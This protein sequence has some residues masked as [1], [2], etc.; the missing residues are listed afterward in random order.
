MPAAGSPSVDPATAG[1]L[2]EEQAR[3][4]AVMSAD[5]IMLETIAQQQRMP[6]SAA[7]AALQTLELIGLVQRQ[8]DGSYVRSP[9]PGLT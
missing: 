6:L 3:L 5:P 8:L 9:G 7:L 2:P 1:D 4:L